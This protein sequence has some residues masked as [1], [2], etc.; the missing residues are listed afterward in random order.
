M[1]AVD[2]IR[3]VCKY[4]A[5]GSFTAL[6]IGYFP[7]GEVDQMQLLLLATLV[8]MACLAADSEVGDFSID[9]A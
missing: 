4:I 1:P 9:I 5:I 6:A 7:S 8:V 3:T 2:R